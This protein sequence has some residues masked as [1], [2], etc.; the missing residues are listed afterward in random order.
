MHCSDHVL[1]VVSCAHNADY[2]LRL[3][4]S[5]GA[6]APEALDGSPLPLAVDEYSPDGSARPK[7]PASYP[8]APAAAWPRRNAF[9]ISYFQGF[10]GEQEEYFR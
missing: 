9:P 2:V 3:G 7:L 10:N 1:L 5:T 4:A 6:K 8:R